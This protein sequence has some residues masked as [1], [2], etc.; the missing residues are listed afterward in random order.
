MA[1][2]LQ[3]DF[4]SRDALRDSLAATFGL[5]GPLSDAFVGGRGE[6]LKRLAAIE[7]DHYAK[8]RNAID[9]AVT[10]LSPYIRRRA[11]TTAEVHHAALAKVDQPWRAGKLVMELAWHDYFQRVYAA[12]GEEGV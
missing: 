1:E 9:G 2:T 7:P 4:A 11:L 3:T 6:G 5:D 12:V 10:Q 8:T